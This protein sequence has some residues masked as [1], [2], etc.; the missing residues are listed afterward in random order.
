MLQ[1]S[2]LDF[3]A[4]LAHAVS[5]AAAA[6][7]LN[8]TPSAVTQRLQELERRVG[9]RLIDRSSRRLLL[10]DEGELLAARGRDISS[11]LAA[12][13]DELAARRDVVTGHLRVLAPLGFG[14]AHV[15][16]VLGAFAAEHPDVT[17]ELSLSDRLGRV[18]ETAWDL[19]IHIGARRDVSLA[20]RRLAPNDRVLCAAPSYLAHAG[21]PE[22]PKQLHTHRCI[23]LRENDEDVTLWR[24]TSPGGSVSQVRIDPAMATNDGDVVRAW[25]LAGRGI[26]MRSEWSIADDLRS[27]RLLRVLPEH[28][29]PSAD[30][31]ALIGPRRGRSARTARFLATLVDPLTPVP[32]RMSTDAPR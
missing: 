28:R 16:P 29:L 12:L 21:V 17:V 1:R 32:W 3:F 10:T 14:R 24:F 26:A 20:V 31:V 13:G 11:A 2:D 9:V 8:V 23:A 18:P 15:A 30:V 22:T 25:A 5:L 27:G 4:T 7:E 6:R 19:A